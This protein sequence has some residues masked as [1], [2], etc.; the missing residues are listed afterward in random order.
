VIEQAEG[1][2]N[3][4]QSAAEMLALFDSEQDGSLNAKQQEVVYELRRGLGQP[5]IFSATCAG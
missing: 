1:L 4:P 5:P 3:L 2:L